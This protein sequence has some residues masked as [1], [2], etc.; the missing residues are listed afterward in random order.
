[1]ARETISE[2]APLMALGLRN[3]NFY[4]GSLLQLRP[5][6]PVKWQREEIG[7]TYI[8]R[9]IT[10]ARRHMVS[11]PEAEQRVLSEMERE[12][13]ELGR[14]AHERKNIIKFDI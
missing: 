14:D 6:P 13:E 1:M 3:E 11:R 8:D 2:L 4:P 10:Y 9:I 12:F 5:M 7:R